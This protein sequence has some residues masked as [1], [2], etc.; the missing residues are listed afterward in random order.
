VFGLTLKNMSSVGIEPTTHGLKVR[1]EPLF[2][3]Q[4]LRFRCIE[5]P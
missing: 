2:L 4:E 1:Q 3:P 5:I